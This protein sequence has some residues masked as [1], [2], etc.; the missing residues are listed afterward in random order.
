MSSISFSGVASGLDTGSIV[1]QL[2]ELRRIPILR[3]E[4]QK[5]D[6]KQSLAALSDLRAAVEK[7]RKASEAL[8]TESEFTSRAARVGT[9]GFFEASATSATPVGTFQVTV[10]QLAQTHRSVTQSFASPDDDVGT[11]DFRFTF[12]ATGEETTVSL[13]AGASSLGDLK[14]AINEADAGVTASIIFDGS[15]YQLMLSADESGAEQQFTVDASGLTGGTAPVFTTTTTGAD[16]QITID[17]SIVVTSPDNTIDGALE[18]SVI[19]L[20]SLG[21]SDMIIEGD[22]TDLGDKLQEFADAFNELRTLIDN[23]GGESGILKGSSLLRSVDGTLSRILS[24]SVSTGDGADE[25]IVAANIGLSMDRY[26]IM[27]L[28]RTKLEEAVDTDYGAVLDLFTKALPDDGEP[29]PWQG[30]LALELADALDIYTLGEGDLKGLIGLREDAANA[31]MD[32]LDSRIEREERSIDLYEATL[33][34]KF[35]AMEQIIAQL[36]QQQGYLF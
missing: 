16:A 11:G 3:Y 36:Q 5:T 24:T 27:S 23:Q 22:V 18:G 1:S 26:G 19:T 31:E 12:G 30:G 17:G 4:A 13:A 2:V 28:D 29:D 9:E 10:D 32:R 21:T 33:T 8:D 20:Q 14:I 34:R 35:T 7:L 15:G 6:L 25:R